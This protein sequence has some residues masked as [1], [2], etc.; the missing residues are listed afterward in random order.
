MSGKSFY[1][2]EKQRQHKI[3]VSATR[4][5][6]FGHI[7]MQPLSKNHFKTSKGFTLSKKT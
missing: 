7:Y 5:T 4:G 3:K 1:L 2:T 6:Y